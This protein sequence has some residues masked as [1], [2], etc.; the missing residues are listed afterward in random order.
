M[1][2]V[3]S[4]NFCVVECGT[5]GLLRVRHTGRRSA[6]IDADSVNVRSETDEEARGDR[7]L[8]SAYLELPSRSAK[9]RRDGLTIAIDKGLPTRY[10]VDLVESVGDHLDFVK[11]GWGTALVSSDL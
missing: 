11:F 6:C 2:S 9:P 1:F 3:T 7:E 10:F 8:V 5:F 4:R